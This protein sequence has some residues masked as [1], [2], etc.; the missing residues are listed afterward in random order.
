[1]TDLAAAAVYQPESL[2]VVEDPDF[3]GVMEYTPIMKPTEL[4]VEKI[5]VKRW[6]LPR[7][8]DT[9]IAAPFVDKAKVLLKLAED[10]TTL[11]SGFA[12][13][14]EELFPGEPVACLAAAFVLSGSNREVLKAL[15]EKCKK[16]LRES[17]MEPRTPLVWYQAVRETHVIMYLALDVAKSPTKIRFIDDNGAVHEGFGLDFLLQHI[18]DLSKAGDWLCR[19][20]IVEPHSIRTDAGNSSSRLILLIHSIIFV[21]NRVKQTRFDVTDEEL[22]EIVQSSKRIRADV[23]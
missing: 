23:S 1:M 7:F 13:K 14:P 12:L 3:V 6:L 18:G 4:D 5:S 9:P 8:S 2:S 11:K 20:L 17:F 16:L 21:R 10:W 22:S 15:D 19:P